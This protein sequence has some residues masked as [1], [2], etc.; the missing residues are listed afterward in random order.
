MVSLT[1]SDEIIK[2]HCSVFYL[3][4]ENNFIKATMIKATRQRR[5]WGFSAEILIK[6]YLLFWMFTYTWAYK[7]GV[8]N[9]NKFFVYK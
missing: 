2:N 1:V 8:Y 7:R 3:Y 4:C 6:E 9:R 5:G